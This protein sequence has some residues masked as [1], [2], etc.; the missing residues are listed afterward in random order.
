MTSEGIGI[1]GEASSRAGAARRDPL[2]TF[3]DLPC[4]PERELFGTAE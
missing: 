2:M 3:L 4:P 1:V